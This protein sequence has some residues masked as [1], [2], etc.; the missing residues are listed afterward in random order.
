MGVPRDE[1]GDA[2][3]CARCG[4]DVMDEMACFN[5]KNW[6]VECCA[7]TGGC[8]YDPVVDGPLPKEVQNALAD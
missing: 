4:E 7:E 5:H 1:N 2:L 6:C 8:C 3:P